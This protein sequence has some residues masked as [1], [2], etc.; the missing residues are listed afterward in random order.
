[1]QCLR[2]SD[3]CAACSNCWAAAWELSG[4]D[5]SHAA[6][7]SVSRTFHVLSSCILCLALPAVGLLEALDLCVCTRR[8]FAASV[9]V[10]L[11]YAASIEYLPQGWRVAAFPRWLHVQSCSTWLILSIVCC[12]FGGSCVRDGLASSLFC[13]LTSHLYSFR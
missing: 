13:L 2:L 7:I 3:A 9:C 12:S 1:M 6:S 4:L 10:S 11:T 8:A 5:D